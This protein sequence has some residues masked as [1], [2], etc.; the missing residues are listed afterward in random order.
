MSLHEYVV[1]YKAW[2]EAHDAWWQWFRDRR[3]EL[4]SADAQ[5]AWREYRCRWCSALMADTHPPT[6]EEKAIVP[7]LGLGAF[8]FPSGTPFAILVTGLTRELD[9]AGKPRRDAAGRPY[10]GPPRRRRFRRGLEPSSEGLPRPFVRHP[11]SS[12]LIHCPGCGRVN[13]LAE[14]R[15]DQ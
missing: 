13:E 2:S 1:A 4:P 5:G 3:A 14:P 9:A 11:K 12:V 10:F 15:W 7:D 6:R 8:G